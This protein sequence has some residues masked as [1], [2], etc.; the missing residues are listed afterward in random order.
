MHNFFKD[1]IDHHICST[2]KYIKKEYVVPKKK[3]PPYMN[4]DREIWTAKKY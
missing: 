3:I 1:N 2:K 4:S